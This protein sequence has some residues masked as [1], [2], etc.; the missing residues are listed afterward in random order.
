MLYV[1]ITVSLVFLSVIIL[2]P[3]FNNFNERYSL[4][5]NYV[6]TLVATL[7]GVLLAIAISNHE[8]D[9]KE[10]EDVIK[11]LGSSM[12]SVETCHDYT[13]K[14]IEYYDSLPKDDE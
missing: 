3:K 2:L 14:L 12:S 9:K 11:L 8:A 5:I 1:V 13:E 6:L 4:S 10:N 7:I